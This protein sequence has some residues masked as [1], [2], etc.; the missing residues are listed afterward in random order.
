MDSIPYKLID[1]KN[2]L[3]QWPVPTYTDIIP[4]YT[5]YIIECMTTKFGTRRRVTTINPYK[6]PSETMLID[7]LNI[8]NID[9]RMIVWL[10]DVQ[11]NY[12]FPTPNPRHKKHKHH[13]KCSKSST[14]NSSS[15][16]S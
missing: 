12:I 9:P 10:T 6:A 2:V 14:S 11:K 7:H 3:R 4:T 5:N 8:E 16:S 1:I 13:C 15:S